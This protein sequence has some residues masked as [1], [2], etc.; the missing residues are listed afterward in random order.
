MGLNIQTYPRGYP[1]DGPAPTY[2]YS[3]YHIHDHQAPDG[4]WMVWGNQNPSDGVYDWTQL[5][6]LIDAVVAEG[7][8]I[9]YTFNGCPTWLADPAKQGTT[10]LYGIPGGMS[11][12]TDM[13]KMGA[14]V[15]ELIS[16][17]NGGRYSV[18]AIK[19]IETWNEPTP[20]VGGTAGS[21][22]FFQGTFTEMAQMCKAVYQAAKAADPDIT[23]LFPSDTTPGVTLIDI[24]NASDGAGGFGRQWGDWGCYHP[25]YRYWQKDL[26]QTQDKDIRIY[27]AAIK[28]NFV[29]GGLPSTT[30]YFIGENGYAADRNDPDL[31]A[32]TSEELS[33]WGARIAIGWATLG[34]KAFQFYCHD[35]VNSGN[36]STSSVVSAGWARIAALQGRTITAVYENQT[37]GRYRVD[38]DIGLL[39]VY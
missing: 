36:P 32:Q 10:W 34:A 29:A 28:T 22:L 33:L 39:D 23:V 3:I 6:L 14:F 16:R 11:A 31:L 35:A 27:V 5:D 9:H 15:T 26:Y 17:Y 25:Y 13:S 21:L 7:K 19:F 24:L 4:E 38:T 12:P 18:K 20:T 37:T 1:S 30:P 2:D 8:Q